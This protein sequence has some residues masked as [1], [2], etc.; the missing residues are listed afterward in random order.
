MNVLV[1]CEE[2]QR[3][4][5]SFR[6]LGHTAW[7]CDIQPCSGGHPEWHILG[8][9]IPIIGG[10]CTFTTEAGGG[11]YAERP[12]GS[13]HRAPAV[14]LSHQRRRGADAGER[15]DRA[16][17]IREYGEGAGIL[18]PAL[19]RAV[20][21]GMRGKSRP[22]EAVRPSAVYADHRAVDV[23]GAVD[24]T[25]LLMAPRPSSPFSDPDRDGRRPTVGERWKQ[26]RE[27]EL[28][29]IPRPGRKRSEKP[30][31]DLL[32]NRPGNG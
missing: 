8:D 16:G 1:A 25:D 11:T 17:T 23:R 10:D 13:Y 22:D 24:E 32:G 6:D 27:R 31:A 28:P 5:T 20:P 9:C 30:G 19:R 26:G 29:A 15:S 12:V 21:A 7:S 18:P 4:C 14:H 3:V 2:S